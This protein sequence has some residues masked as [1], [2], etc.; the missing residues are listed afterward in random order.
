[1]FFYDFIFKTMEL[2]SGLGPLITAGIFAASL[3]SALACLVSGPKIFQ[4]LISC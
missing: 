4:V 2:Q 3:S 1:M